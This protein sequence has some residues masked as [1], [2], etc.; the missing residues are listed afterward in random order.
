MDGETVIDPTLVGQLLVR[1]CR[2]DPLALLT[3]REQG[4]LGHI[5]EG[6]TNRVIAHRLGAT[7][8]PSKGTSP[9]SFTSGA[10]PNPSLVTK[11]ARCTRMAPLVRPLCNALKLRGPRPVPTT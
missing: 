8:E 1:R 3:G 10:S 9:R 11:G 2:P 4:V 5:A 6:I 7:E